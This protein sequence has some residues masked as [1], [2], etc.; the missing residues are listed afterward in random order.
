METIL[1]S[2]EVYK[3]TYMKHK[4]LIEE[5]VKRIKRNEYS[6]QIKKYLASKGIEEEE[7]QKALLDE[8]RA[9]IKA[10]TLKSLPMKNK[11]IFGTFLTL[12]VVTFIFFLF[13]L[14]NYDIYN[15]TTFYA[16]IGVL[17]FIV[18]G[19]MSIV[20]YKRWTPELMELEL[21][22]K[23]KPDYG[24]FL[25]L[26][27]I[28]GVIMVFL[29][30]WR[31]SAAEDRI[32]KETQ[33]QTTGTIISGYSKTSRRSSSAQV[34][35]RFK[36]K[37][38]Q[39]RTESEE[40][41]LNEF[42]RYYKGQR[43]NM[44]YSSKYPSII[45]LLTIASNIREFT[46]SEERNLLPADLEAIITEE[47][48]PTAKG[49]N[50]ISLGWQ[51]DPSSSAWYN[52]NKEAAIKLTD[53]G[54]AYVC[55]FI[56]AREFMKALKKSDYKELKEGTKR[57]GGIVQS[58]YLENDSFLVHIETQMKNSSFMTVIQMTKK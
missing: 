53:V 50:K 43:V 5:I 1:R 28:P 6:Y 33:V 27:L 17:L 9:I 44:I 41:G 58:Q 34:T 49:L 37:N 7:K 18:F 22:G 35:V 45:K 16:I 8:A 46:N 55:D 32:L 31:F 3:I 42:N 15:Y 54:V 48:I 39:V 40:V 29:L 25:V 51:E 2:F 13:V 24:I 36:T 52:E 38:G 47:F 30:L 57:V 4:L 26:G 11:M 19:M 23:L 12:T 14:P 56:A 21:S 20:Y 10:D